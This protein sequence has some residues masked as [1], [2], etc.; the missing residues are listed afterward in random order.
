[1]NHAIDVMVRD[2]EQLIERAAASPVPTVTDLPPHFTDDH[3]ARAR[4][5]RAA[6]F[7]P[8]RRTRF[9]TIR[10]NRGVR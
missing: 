1:V 5:H 8:R 10:K 4:D 6:W 7:Q 9:S 3:S 2:Y